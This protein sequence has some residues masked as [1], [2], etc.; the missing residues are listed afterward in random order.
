VSNTTS[1]GSISVKS[2]VWWSMTSSAPSW[3]AALTLDP[4]AVA[5]T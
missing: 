5:M 1:T 3:A 2:S 4:V